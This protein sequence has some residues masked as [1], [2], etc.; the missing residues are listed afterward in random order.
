MQCSL[1]LE[2]KFKKW[3]KRKKK[4]KIHSENNKK[5]LKCSVKNVNQSINQLNVGNV[6]FVKFHHLFAGA[7]EDGE[8][9]GAK[10]LCHFLF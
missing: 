1:H 2:S 5:M 6:E 3:K 9:P 7:C 10:P 8:G 4:Y